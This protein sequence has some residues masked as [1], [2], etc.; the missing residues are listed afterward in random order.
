MM[1]DYD[2][3]QLFIRL[4][5]FDREGWEGGPSANS[6]LKSTADYC[7]SYYQAYNMAYVSFS[8]EATGSVIDNPVCDAGF[9][10]DCAEPDTD[11]TKSMGYLHPEHTYWVTHLIDMVD[12]QWTLSIEYAEYNQTKSSSSNYTDDGGYYETTF[13]LESLKGTDTTYYTPKIYK[14]KFDCHVYGT[15]YFEDMKRTTCTE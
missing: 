10:F 1:D 6:T 13:S 4:R 5:M 14:V 9:C 11:Y 2:E 7:N 8:D 12:L 3:E 15:C